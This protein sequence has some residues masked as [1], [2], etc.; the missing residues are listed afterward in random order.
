M[1]LDLFPELPVD[2]SI[3]AGIISGPR[4]DPTTTKRATKT[5][6]FNCELETGVT[7]G[8]VAWQRHGLYEDL[9]ADWAEAVR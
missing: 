4:R 5:G 3:S 9:H 7:E 6:F 8:M 2:K 1:L